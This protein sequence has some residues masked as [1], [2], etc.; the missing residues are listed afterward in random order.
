VFEKMTLVGFE[1]LFGNYNL[2][3]SPD[4]IH[5]CHIKTTVPTWA[6][7]Q[8]GKMVFDFDFKVNSQKY[9]A[10]PS[11][12]TIK[13]TYLNLDSSNG[14]TVSWGS[15]AGFIRHGI[16]EWVGHGQSGAEAAHQD[17]HECE[18]FHDCL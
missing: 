15:I 8:V 5:N 2:K 3:I 14:T 6:F 7:A 1:I 17:S 13:N 16:W 10:V 4:Q 12:N 11:L 9:M 18:K